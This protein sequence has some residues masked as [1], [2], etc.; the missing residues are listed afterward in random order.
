MKKRVWILFLFCFVL[1][2]AS[3]SAV[4][5]IVSNSEDW[6]DVYSTIQYANFRGIPYNFLVSQRHPAI[7]LQSFSP[8]TELQIISSSRFPFVIG[9]ENMVESAG[10]EAEELVFDSAN[11]ELARLLPDIKNFVVIDDS[12]G[13]NAISLAPYGQISESYVLFADSENIDD[14]ADFLADRDPDNVM[15]F[16]HVDREVKDALAIYDPEIINKEGDRFEN[17]LE[18]VRKY[19]EINPTKQVILTNGEFIEHE[20]MAGAEPVIFIGSTNVPQQ[21]RDF[22]HEH[23]IEVGVLIGNQYVGSA[24]SIKRQTGMSVFVKFARSARI[25]TSAVSPVEGLDL[26]Y[27]PR[28]RLSL[29]IVDV[30]YNQLTNQ[31][32]VTFRNNAELAT[33]FIGTYKLSWGDGERQTVGDSEAIFIDGDEYRTITYDVGAMYGDITGEIYVIYGESGGSLENVI[34]LTLKLNITEVKD[35]SDIVIRQVMYDKVRREFIVE[36]ENVGDV[37]TYVDLELVDIIIAGEKFTFGT[38]KVVH[39]KSGEKKNLRIKVDLEEVDFEDNEKIRIVAWY[40][41]RENNLVLRKEDTYVV[42][43]RGV[44]YLIYS[45]WP[46]IVV[47]LLLI[48]LWFIIFMRKKVCPSCKHK[49]PRR[50]RYCEKCGA[51]LRKSS[52]H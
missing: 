7:L 5:K 38:D 24:T 32:E 9:Y 31:L 18:I 23:G 35:N 15:L 6:R 2:I 22:I 8:G 20:I 47:I 29:E 42:S 19:L 45:A 11:L 52:N 51:D 44:G 28:V 16:G 34:E 48:I 37:D 25:A 27:L 14:V 36:V 40:G 26:F 39:I 10:Y 30:V 3:V 33:Y 50:R 21:V 12:Y 17:N 43:Y 46:V 41:E 1:N 49:N 4:N 13:Y